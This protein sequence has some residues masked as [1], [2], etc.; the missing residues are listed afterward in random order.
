[1]AAVVDVASRR[2]SDLL[3]TEE[4]Q[5]IPVTMRRPGTPDNFVYN[6]DFEHGLNAWNWGG[7]SAQVIDQGQSG[8]CLQ[9]TVQPNEKS[10]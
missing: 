1:M 8:K 6:G 5:P 9:L 3:M 7:A 4:P 10:E 2:L